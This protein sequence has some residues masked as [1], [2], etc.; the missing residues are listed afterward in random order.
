MAVEPAITFYGMFLHAKTAIFQPVL[1][2]QVES[3]VIRVKP[4]EYGGWKMVGI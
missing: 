3:K 1:G 4:E 2:S